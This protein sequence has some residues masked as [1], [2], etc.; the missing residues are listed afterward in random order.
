M[1]QKTV[2]VDTRE[3]S[4]AKQNENSQNE[5]DSKDTEKNTDD[6]DSTAQISSE[7]IDSTDDIS[8][9]DAS[10][11]NA[12]EQNENAPN[13]SPES[14]VNENEQHKEDTFDDSGNSSND[15]STSDTSSDDTDKLQENDF[16][17]PMMRRARLYRLEDDNWEEVGTG[18][19]AIENRDDAQYITLRNQETGAAFFATPVVTDP[20]WDEE[21]RY[22]VCFQ[23]L[24]V[25]SIM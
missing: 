14:S 3:A 25:Y 22:T 21:S 1:D 4:E 18:V 12:D 5:S 10:T 15:D 9:S 2:A 13:V 17:N 16:S 23:L 8:N 24:L 19:A 20:N 11:K 6:K 7:K